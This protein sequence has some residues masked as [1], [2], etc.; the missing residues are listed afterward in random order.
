MGGALSES[1]LAVKKTL[2]SAKRSLVKSSSAVEGEDFLMKKVSFRAKEISE[3][4][5]KSL[6]SQGK[7]R[8]RD[9]D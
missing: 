2:K 5:L 8:I 6:S 1:N 3:L 4:N 9:S 7:E